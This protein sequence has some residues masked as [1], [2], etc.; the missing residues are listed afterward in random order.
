MELNFICWLLVMTKLDLLTQADFTAL[1]TRVFWRYMTVMRLLQSSYW[2]EPAGPRLDL[3][4]RIL[5]SDT[6]EQVR[7]AC[8]V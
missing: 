3:S 2:L 5:L 7:M 4:W 8:M 6:S 1:V